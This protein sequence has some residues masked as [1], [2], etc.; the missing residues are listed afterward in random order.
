M[1]WFDHL[2]SLRLSPGG[3]LR[4]FRMIGEQANRPRPP[5]QPALKCPRCDLSMMLTQDRQRNT[6]FRYWR[7]SRGHGRLTTFFDFLREKDFIRPLSPQQL[8]DLRTHV[9]S[10]N[11]SNCGA[12]IDLAAASACAHCGTPL[13]MLD[14]KQIERMA[15]ELGEADEASRT[16]DPALPVR[17]ALERAHVEALFARAHGREDGTVSF[18]LVGTALRALA[19]WLK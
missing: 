16:V 8:A 15:S 12:P 1:I 10:V 5:Q 17:L 19:N 13:S 14:L 3:T 9:Q 4:L 18:D 2:E 11:C 6:A 7:C